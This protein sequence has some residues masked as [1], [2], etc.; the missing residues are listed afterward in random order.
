V[1]EIKPSGKNASVRAVR[2][3]TVMLAFKAA[4]QATHEGSSD[5][6]VSR[7]WRRALKQAKATVL[8]GTVD[9]VPCLWHP[10]SSA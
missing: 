5:D 6:A 2:K 8:E 3:E 7:A 1:C 9:G 10:E 4:Y